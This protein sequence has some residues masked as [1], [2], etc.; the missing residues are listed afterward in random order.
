MNSAASISLRWPP[1]PPPPTGWFQFLGDTN[2]LAFL[3][4][5]LF[6]IDTFFKEVDGSGA[7]VSLGGQRL[8][9]FDGV[10]FSATSATY[11]ITNFTFSAANGA[12]FGVTAVP[13]PAT[14]ALA[15]L[16]LAALGAS[17]R[18]HSLG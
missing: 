5:G 15:L 2:P 14:L 17:R 8:G 16:A 6:D 4:A 10:R 3:N 7:V 11:G 9:L 13:A 12:S 18:R 1:H